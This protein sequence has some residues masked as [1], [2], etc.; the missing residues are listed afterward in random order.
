MPPMPTSD[1]DGAW[2]RET[3]TDA[4]G[5]RWV[6]DAWVARRRGR[7][8]VG[9]IRVFPADRAP[10]TPGQPW[11]GQAADVPHRGLERRLLRGVPVTRYSASALSWASA[12]AQS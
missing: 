9:E 4:H 12:M 6:G 8:V 3:R 11:R 2:T 7:L 1:R 10:E 5:A